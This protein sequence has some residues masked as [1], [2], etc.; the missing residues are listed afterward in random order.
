[1]LSFFAMILI[2]FGAFASVFFFFYRFKASL[3]YYRVDKTYCRFLLQ[4]AIADDLPC[5]DWYLF[6]G[7]LNL[8]NDELEQLRLA[9]FDI[10]E[11]YAR[12]SVVRNAKACMRFSKQGK[13]ELSVLLESLS[14]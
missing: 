6:I 9:C 4:H 11:Q 1:M 13:C 12:E 2:A 14:H 7:A 5:V 3:P 10:D 8:V